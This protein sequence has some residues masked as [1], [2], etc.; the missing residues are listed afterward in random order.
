MQRQSPPGRSKFHYLEKSLVGPSGAA[1]KLGYY[2]KRA[3]QTV[4][5]SLT[6]IAEQNEHSPPKFVL[7]S[8]MRTVGGKFSKLF[9]VASLAA[10][11]IGSCAVCQAANIDMGQVNATLN[12]SPRI[13]PADLAEV[14]LLNYGQHCG[15]NYDTALSTSEVLQCQNETDNLNRLLISRRPPK[16]IRAQPIQIRTARVN[17]AASIF[18]SNWSRQIRTPKVQLARI[19]SS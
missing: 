2:N 5:R 14:S 11:L 13:C 7:G 8:K 16:I 6:K 9:F 17:P 12:S 1:D 4:S 19:Y 18:P 15:Q 3:T 10:P